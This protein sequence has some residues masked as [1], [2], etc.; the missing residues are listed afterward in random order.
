MAGSY[1]NKTTLCTLF[2]HKCNDMYRTAQILAELPSALR[3]IVLGNIGMNV[4]IPLLQ[5]CICKGL[6][7]VG[8]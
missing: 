7:L 8:E 5:V 6:L 4:N 1:R 3:G 2:Q